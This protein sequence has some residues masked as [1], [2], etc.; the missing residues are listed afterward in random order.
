MF[1]RTVHFAS[2][3]QFPLTENAL[4][5]LI[6]L[7]KKTTYSCHRTES[8]KFSFKLLGFIC[9]QH[10]L[11]IKKKNICNKIK[12]AQIFSSVQLQV[13]WQI[14]VASLEQTWPGG[15]RHYCERKQSFNGIT[16]S[17]TR[18]LLLEAPGNLS[19]LK[20]YFEISLKKSWGRSYL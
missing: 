11:K 1:S 6:P 18:G 10:I 16:R 13:V 14:H 20:S 2:S 15:E 4:H 12:V 19:G 3:W 5:K 9:I 7:K 17:W 8:K